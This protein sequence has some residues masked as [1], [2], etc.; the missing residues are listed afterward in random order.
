MVIATKDQ[1]KDVWIQN[2]MDKLGFT[3]EQAECY[4]NTISEQSFLLT[5]YLEPQEIEM[6]TWEE[7]K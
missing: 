7:T 6:F 2:V 1:I 5:F 3:K 4:F